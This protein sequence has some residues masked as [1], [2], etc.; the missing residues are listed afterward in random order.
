MPIL[1][2]VSADRVQVGSMLS[3]AMFVRIFSLLFSLAYTIYIVTILARFLFSKSYIPYTYALSSYT[4]ISYFKDS[5]TPIIARPSNPSASVTVQMDSSSFTITIPDVATT[6]AL[7]AFGPPKLLR[8]FI[9]LTAYTPYGSTTDTLDLAYSFNI[10]DR[11][12]AP[13]ASLA[14][15]SYF[16]TNG[17]GSACPSPVLSGVPSDTYDNTVTCNGT[18]A[19]PLR[20]TSTIPDP[21]TS[22]IVTQTFVALPGAIPI[23]IRTVLMHILVVVLSFLLF[24]SMIYNAVNPIAAKLCRRLCLTRTYDT[25]PV[26]LWIV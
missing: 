1:A 4:L 12:A 7:D 18:F 13:A 23:N 6:P 20:F 11:A 3:A 19:F 17:S 16:Q 25:S 26:A 24:F 2:R 8:M 5:S 15:L 21:K 9:N 14:V 10:A 22:F